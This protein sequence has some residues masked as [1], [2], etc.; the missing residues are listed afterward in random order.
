MEFLCFFWD[1]GLSVIS[2]EILRD[3]NDVANTQL[4]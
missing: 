2:F 1:L 3:E 4:Y